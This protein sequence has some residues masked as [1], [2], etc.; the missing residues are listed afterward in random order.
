M[1]FGAV[2]LSGSI[3]LADPVNGADLFIQGAATFDFLGES[4]SG[5]GDVNGDGMDE[6]LIG[7]PNASRDGRDYAGA[8]YVVF[9]AVDLSGSIDLADPVN[10]ADLFIQGAA[11]FD[12][13]G[14]S[15]RGGRRQRRWHRRS[16]HWR[17]NA[18][19]DGRDYAGASYVVFGA[20]DLSGTIDLADPV[21]GADLF[22]QGAATSNSLGE[23]ASGAG[24]VNGDG[25][26]DLLIGAPTRLGTA[27]AMPVPA[28]W[29][30]ARWTCRAPSIWQIP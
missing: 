10:G 29:C 23:S 6:L 19:R 27:V 2:D 8:S 15:Q 1:V 20:V 11:T 3:D 18:S 30:S 7:A 25:I 21:N 4:A 5:A 12:F 28:M 22:I 17:P 9:G 14:E 26:D 24:D 16:A 13:L